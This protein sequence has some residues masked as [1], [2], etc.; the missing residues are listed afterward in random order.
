M[1]NLE[2]TQVPAML[3]PTENDIAL[4]LAAK[5]H[6][7]TKNVSNRMK[8]YVFDRRADGLQIIHLGKTWEKLILAARVLAILEPESIYVTFSTS[9]ARRPAMKLSQYIGGKCNQDKFV[10]GTFTNGLEEPNV[11][12]CMDPKTD[13]QAVQESNK[14]NMPVIAF[15]N[16]HCSLKYIDIAIPC[17]N[18]GSQ[19]LGLMCW[20]LSR[21]ILRIRGTLSYNI[22]WDVLPDMFFYSD[23][24][25][26]DDENQRVQESMSKPSIWSNPTTF[27]KDDFSYEIPY[28]PN[29]WRENVLNDHENPSS[30]STGNWA[31]DIL[32]EHKLPTSWADDIPE[33]E[34]IEG[35]SNQTSNTHTLFAPFKTPWDD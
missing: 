20:F 22:T 3:E 34:G 17:N 33:E 21:A 11:L 7:G 26:E 24:Q 27:N 32:Q 28:A 13:F 25:H 35:E 19:S 23:I 1:N 14:C 15:T 30:F 9:K 6:V 16:T 4:L 2:N 5:C 29:S 8:K 31:T 18:M 12:I 10:P